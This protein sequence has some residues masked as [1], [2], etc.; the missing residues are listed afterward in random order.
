MKNTQ[1]RCVHVR[2]RFERIV[3]LHLEKQTLETFVPSCRMRE[4]SPGSK[5]GIE[6]P[7]IPGYV[8]LKCDS[9]QREALHAIPGVLTIV[10]SAD[11]NDIVPA[12]EIEDLQRVVNSGISCELWPHLPGRS[13]TVEDG[14]LQGITG[15]LADTMGKRRLVLP[16]SLLGQS[17]AVEID[18]S[19]RLDLAHPPRSEALCVHD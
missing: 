15:V 6:L 10:R 9:V 5:P 4:R 3:A 7:L 1:W 14:P 11:A 2:K 13:V 17:V 12:H 8:F 19:C 18:D 16:I